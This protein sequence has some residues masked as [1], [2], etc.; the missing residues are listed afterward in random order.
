MQARLSAVR[1]E[2]LQLT[3]PAFHIVQHKVAQSTGR[4]S[5]DSDVYWQLPHQ[6]GV[7]RI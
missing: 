1:A 5:G 7:Y 4:L 6:R 2:L 3:Q